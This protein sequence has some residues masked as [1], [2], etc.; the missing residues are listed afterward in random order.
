M[1]TNFKSMLM[2]KVTM[3]MKTKM[4]KTM[5]MKTKAYLWSMVIYCL[6]SLAISTAWSVWILG[7]DIMIIDQQC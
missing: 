7:K 2:T 5:M 1:A 4:M 3:M 6:I